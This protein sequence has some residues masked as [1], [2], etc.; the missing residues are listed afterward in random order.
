MI[1]YIYTF[2]NGKKYIGQTCQPLNER[3]KKGEGYINS[4]AVYA[5]IKKYGWENLQIETFSCSS[6]EEMDFLES[7]YIRFY[8][9]FDKHYGY[10]LT[11]GGEG[12]IKYDRKLISELWNQGLPI[13]EIAEQVGC[14]GKTVTNILIDEEIYS[15]DEVRLRRNKAIANSNT[16]KSLKEYYSTEEHKKERIEN[17]LKGAKIR[18]KPVYV[19]KDKEQKD[20]IGFYESGRQAAKALNIDHS[21]PSYALNH[22]NYSKG[23]WFFYEKDLIKPINI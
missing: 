12:S 10:N 11:F 4:P 18:S 19:F 14:N 2:P 20:F 13:K 22:N 6:K 1:V 3:A 15:K 8:N 23:Y 17:G 9:T 5:A 21:L 7:Y 16:V